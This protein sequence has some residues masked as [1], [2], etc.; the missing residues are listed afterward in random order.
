MISKIDICNMALA[1]LGQEPLASLTQDD[2]R[3]RRCHLFYE[4]VKKEVLRTHN[5]PLPM[6]LLPCPC[7]L[8]TA[9]RTGRICMPIR[10]TACSCAA[11]LPR[12][13]ARTAAGRL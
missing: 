8:M 1:Q 3:A 5:W 10:R 11:C 12:N 4:P 2:E 7:W 6:L 13:T 9:R